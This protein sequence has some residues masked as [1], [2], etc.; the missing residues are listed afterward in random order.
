L[1][2]NGYKD[3][4]SSLNIKSLKA[5]KENISS[6]EY[7]KS[8]F[9]NPIEDAPLLTNIVKEILDRDPSYRK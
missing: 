6:K 3:K 7:D 2:N 4:L 5:F 1:V 9:E 8:L